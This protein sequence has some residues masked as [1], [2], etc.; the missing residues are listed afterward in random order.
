MTVLLAIWLVGTLWLRATTHYL[1]ET[2][3]LLIKRSGFVWM[4]ILFR[5]IEDFQYQAFF[6][7]KLWQIRLYQLGFRRMLRIRKRRGFRYVLINPRDPAPI[8]EAIQEF[9]TLAA[10]HCPDPLPHPDPELQ[11][12]GRKG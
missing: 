11:L 12:P 5:D 1:V 7:S 10:A 3:R 2:D 4:E 6:L 8:I 9:A